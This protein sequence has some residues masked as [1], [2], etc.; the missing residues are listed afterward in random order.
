MR[1]CASLILRN[2][3]RSEFVEKAAGDSAR[4]AVAHP[5]GWR[6]QPQKYFVSS[7]KRSSSASH[8]PSNIPE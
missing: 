7:L 8:A 5:A 4:E 1:R 3:R 2:R 6:L